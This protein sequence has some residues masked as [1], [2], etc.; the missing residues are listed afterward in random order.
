MTFAQWYL[1]NVMWWFTQW[2]VV[3]KEVT[4]S[5]DSF[6]LVAWIRIYLKWL[7]CRGVHHYEGSVKLYFFGRLRKGNVTSRTTVTYVDACVVGSVRKPGK[8][9]K[10]SVSKIR[11]CLGGNG[12]AAFFTKWHLLQCASTVLRYYKFFFLK[13]D[14]VFEGSRVGLNLNWLFCPVS[15]LCN[16]CRVTN[17]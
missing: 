9:H 15:R 7:F 11:L 8:Y 10:I 16:S 6:I 12:L 3:C 5:K 13:R 14:L 4:S 1:V 2:C 17:S